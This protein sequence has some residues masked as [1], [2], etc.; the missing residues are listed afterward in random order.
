MN[1]PNFLI[2]FEIENEK[3][4]ILEKF[5]ETYPDYAPLI[6]DDF[7]VL[8]SA[9]LF[10]MNRYINYINYTI[11]QNY[12]EFSS[13]EYLDALVALAGIERFKGTPFVCKIKITATTP[14]TLPKGT[15]FKDN[16]GHNAYLAKDEEIQ[17]ESI[18]NIE[19]ESGLTQDYDTTTLEIP[20]IYIK[21][22]QKISPFVQEKGIESDADLKKRF[23]LSLSRPSTAGNL[24]SYQYYCAIPEVSKSKIIHQG[25]GQVKVIYVANSQNALLKLK[26]NIEDKIPL[27]D[28]VSYIEATP[29]HCNLTITL[30]LKSNDKNSLIIALVHHNVSSLFASLDIGEEVSDSKVIAS[31]FVDEMIVDICVDG[32]KESS[33]DGILVLKDLNILTQVGRARD[34]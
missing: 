22:I 1:L 23:L 29:I 18:V 21:E 32:L 28:Q 31:A 9:F 8:T 19:L 24:K 20:N 33:P 16:A 17:E 25:L 11:A 10:R 13:G 15:K 3:N 4:M 30:S 12:L 5:K 26:E 6:G 34:E 7:S 27:T 14:L 2:P